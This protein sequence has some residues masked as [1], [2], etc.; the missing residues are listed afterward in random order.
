[1]GNIFPGVSRSL[2]NHF[3]KDLY[4]CVVHAVEPPVAADDEDDLD[5]PVERML[6]K[7]GCLEKHFSVQ[8]CI[9]ETKDWRKCQ[10]QVQDFKECMDIYKKKGG[11]TA[12]NK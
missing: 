3:R 6:K 7:T 8:E 4:F 5:D 2:E 11:N 12:I 9:A 10:K 1:M